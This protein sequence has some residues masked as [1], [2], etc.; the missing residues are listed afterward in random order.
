MIQFVDLG[1]SNRL[2]KSKWDSFW[3]CH[4]YLFK[5][6][7][8]LSY[9]VQLHPLMNMN[10]KWIRNMMWLK[11]LVSK[12]RWQ[13]YATVSQTMR[14]TWWKIFFFFLLQPFIFPLTFSP[15]SL[16]MGNYDIT[17]LLSYCTEII[18][19]SLIYITRGVRFLERANNAD[20]CMLLKAVSIAFGRDVSIIVI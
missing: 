20:T 14:S 12:V 13:L 1:I 9:T 17:R 2:G 10:P 8:S 6:S 16:E 15:Y 3:S 18:I 5:S 7:I 11:E 4:V 19:K